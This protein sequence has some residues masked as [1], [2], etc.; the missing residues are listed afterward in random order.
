[1][2]RDTGF[3]VG[4]P[5]TETLEYFRAKGSFPIT[6]NWW[7][8]WQ[9]EHTRAFTVAGV[10]NVDILM[11]IYADLDKI[12]AEGGT[13]AKW[14]ADVLPRLQSAIDN[15][16]APE[17]IIT[18]R[19][20]RIIYDT[21]LRVARAAGQWKRIEA[22]KPFQPYLIY[23][24][25][26]DS[27]TR[28]LHRIWGGIDPG[29][30]RII[31]PVD[32]PA[33]RQFYPPNGWN[34]RCDVIQT[35]EASLKRRGLRVT[36]DAELRALGWPTADGR[37]KA[38]GRDVVRGD[39]IIDFVPNGIDPGFAYNPGQVHLAGTAEHLRST[40]DEAA[41]TNLPL[42]RSL[43]RDIV[44]ST[45]FDA[46]LVNPQQSFPVMVLAPAERQILQAE[47]SVVILS[48]DTYAKQLLAHPELTL[49]DYRKLLDLGET[50][51]L[52]FRQG[53]LRLILIRADGGKWLKAT[54]KVTADRRELYMVSYQYADNREINR[55]RRLLELVYDANSL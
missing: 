20:L 24:A 46:F 42:A 19:R 39:G 38:L 37:N 22:L 44:G 21:N 9:E 28:P 3:Q 34:C 47:T 29:T 35:S 26:R 36:S 17:N 52:I 18:D 13:F 7:E 5:P 23:S 30:R 11:A 41:Q 31:L 25:V 16:H 6:R 33:W 10:T 55:L 8:I 14:K 4:L 12:I 53:D 15:N 40:I 32:H 45:A 2:P 49:A 54:V 1:M 50:P 27:F 43:L 51:Q 48:S